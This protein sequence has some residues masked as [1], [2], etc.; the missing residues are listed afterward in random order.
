VVSDQLTVLSI[1]SGG[2]RHWCRWFTM[3]QFADM[4]QP[5]AGSE[6]K[7]RVANQTGLAGSY[8]FTLYYTSG[9]KLRA[10]AAAVGATAKLAGDA[11]AAPASGLSVVDAFRKELGLR[12][13]KQS[14]TYPALILDHIEQIPT[15]N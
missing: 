9:R 4:A 5:M 14:G 13:E 15:K 3:D 7:N 1:W 6:I 11:S 2:V 8:D 12:L 10:D